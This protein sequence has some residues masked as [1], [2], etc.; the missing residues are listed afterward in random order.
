MFYLLYPEVAGGKGPH[1]RMDTST[2]PPVVEHLEYRFE[3]YDGEA[4]VTTFPCFIVTQTL[5]K[6]LEESSLHGYLLG[7]VEVSRSAEMEELYPTVELP[8]FRLLTINGVPTVD[9]FGLLYSQDLIVSE[10]ALDIL[11]DG[12]LVN[13]IVEDYEELI[14]VGG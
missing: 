2:H 6:C 11:Q 14:V 4:L 12:F 8:E 9:D 10:A 13:C 3:A 1:T 5:A 7:E